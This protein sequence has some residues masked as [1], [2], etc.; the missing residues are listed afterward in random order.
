M[1]ESVERQ[2]T[3]LSAAVHDALSPLRDA[4]VSIDAGDW[5]PAA[6]ADGLLD[7]RRETLRVAIPSDA[8]MVLLRL[9]DAHFNVVTLDLLSTN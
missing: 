3:A 2:G 9:T 7:G 6:T 1:L 5:Q 8:R 4:V